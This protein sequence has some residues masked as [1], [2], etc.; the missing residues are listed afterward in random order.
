MTLGSQIL[1]RRAADGQPVR[2]TSVDS[3]LA[4]SAGRGWKGLTAEHQHLPPSESDGYMDGDL[5]SVQVGPPSDLR[6]WRGGRE[7]RIPLRPWNVLL[8]PAG[9]PTRLAWT[10]PSEVLNLLL[11]P[12]QAARVQQ[13]TVLADPVIVHLARALLAGLGLPPSPGE[14]LFSDGIRDVLRAHLEHRHAP[15]PPR[16][17]TLSPVE[18]ER[19]DSL[20]EADLTASLS[21]DDLASQVP[22]SPAHFARVFKRSTGVTPHAYVL[23]R[24][25][26]AARQLLAT[27]PHG[28]SHLAHRTGFADAS[29][30]A[31]QFRRHLGV[32]PGAY[33]SSLRR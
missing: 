21:V 24:R 14:R 20:I 30:L 29:H 7:H 23:R 1:V 26:E 22:M 15:S 17:R 8:L 5:L 28:L 9:E 31:R 18:L 10:G 2:L 3:I 32:T 4:S 11:A 6:V 33:R 13:A 27:T 25:V 19:V 12:G 16:V